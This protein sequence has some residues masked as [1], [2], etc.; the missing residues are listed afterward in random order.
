MHFDSILFTDTD[1][2]VVN[3]KLLLIVY[4]SAQFSVAATKRI[5]L[6]L[7]STTKLTVKL[8]PVFLIWSIVTTVSRNV[9]RY[10][11]TCVIL[12]IL[13]EV[14]VTL[15]ESS[16]KYIP[17]EEHLDTSESSWNGEISFVNEKK[18]MKQEGKC[19]VQ[20]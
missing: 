14:S 3:T 17:N 12:N 1:D 8:Q 20:L 19:L 13:L 4:K 7:V 15:F 18:E 10:F 16:D 11:N 5:R 2:A 9:Y 6:V